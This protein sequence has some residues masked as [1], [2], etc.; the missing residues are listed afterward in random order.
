LFFCLLF[1]FCVSSSLVL[2]CHVLPYLVMSC[3]VLFYLVMF[4]IACLLLS[5]P[6]PLLSRSKNLG[7]P[8][9]SQDT[10]KLVTG[11]SSSSAAAVITTSHP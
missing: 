7:L 11:P 1:T 9:I 10:K 6:F 8:S 2:S 4:G 5:G 3:R